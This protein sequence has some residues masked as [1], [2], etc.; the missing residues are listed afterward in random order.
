VGT[1]VDNYREVLLEKISY[2][3]RAAA[4]PIKDRQSY[5]EAAIRQ[6]CRG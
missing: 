2:C 3:G 6:Y 4:Q 5:V 1:G